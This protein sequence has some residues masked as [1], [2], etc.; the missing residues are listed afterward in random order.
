[1]Q[2]MAKPKEALKGKET[3]KTILFIVIFAS[4]TIYILWRLFFTLPL[5]HGIAS[6]V[7][8]I[9]LWIAESGTTVEAFWHFYNARYVKIPELPVIPD[10][11]YP[12]VDVLICTHNESREL[13]YKTLN[14]CK[15]MKYPDKSKV[16]IYLC[17]DANRPD[18]R[19]L[20][21]Q[22]NVGYF[23]F[24]GNKHAKAGN[25]NYALPH[26]SSPL[27]AIF[28]ADMIPTSEF[29]LETV[30][31][32][33]LRD[34][35]KKNGEWRMLL[36]YERR[37]GKELG[38]V[39][40]MQSFY[41][42][43]PLQRNLYMESEA[44]NEQDYFYRAV[45]VARTNS[46]SAAFAGS[47]TVFLRKALEDAGGFA[48]YSI[49][50]DLAT[51]IPILSSGYTSMAVDKELAHGLS[52]EDAFNFI[53]QRK[54]WSRGSAQVIPNMR[55]LRSKL[56]LKSKWSF[57]ISYFYWWTF[58]RRFIYLLT[59]ILYGLFGIAV[60]DVTLLQL[61]AVWL[62]Y[63]LIYN[64]GLRYMSGETINALWSS[65]IDTIQF[66][67]LM[68][69]VIAGT[70]K[71]PEKKFWVTP[72][73]RIKGRNSS[74]KLAVP[75]IVLTVLSIYSIT[76]CL[77]HIFAFRYSGAI[78]VLFW[79]VYNLFCLL[80][81][82]VYY[83]GRVN[84]RDYQRIPASVGATIH[85]GYQEFAG[86]T[87]YISEDSMAVL[88]KTPEY[89]PVDEDFAVTLQEGNYLATMKV[90]LNHVQKMRSRWRYSL[91][92]TEID[93]INKNEYLQIL[94][95][96]NHPYARKI[97][98]DFDTVIKCV[99]RGLTR[100]KSVQQ[101]KLP[102]ID[103]PLSLDTSEIGVVKSIALDYKNI[104]LS[105]N[106]EFP[107]ELTI[108]FSNLIQCVCTKVLDTRENRVNRKQRIALYEINNWKNLAK[109]P[110]FRKTIFDL[111]AVQSKD[112]QHTEKILDS[113]TISTKSDLALHNILY[114]PI[115]GEKEL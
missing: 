63:Y 96:R 81:S 53:K 87:I 9:I 111:M 22:M 90:R 12:D 115:K 85:T 56:P 25:L 94:Y 42:S 97:D 69:P 37:K 1:M 17:D 109:D 43:D 30:P 62:P 48:T 95:D 47:N 110:A 13:L 11:L 83:Y 74:L 20:T 33:F 75:H 73:E 60:A 93:A 91:S 18:I 24:D 16:H 89:L 79:L 76:V 66:P 2:Y 77:R 68:W 23:G 29:L 31:Y 6:L 105:G 106:K 44:P 107:N 3:S 86:Q 50:E 54:R 15:Y 102:Q 99:F 70:L 51:S 58:I 65:I 14:G 78:I 21:E 7:W 88:L 108:H 101:N 57:I 80:T 8:G 112:T 5:H 82:I 10:N 64:T 104:T 28:D 71:I 59:P 52:P 27:I 113:K 40:T 103:L 45:N 35:V 92:I 46:E 38:Y 72:K 19:R 114:K 36:P 39:Q 61:L 26:T 84:D 55:F 32:F 49:T 67:Y 34:M 4:S 100:K 41:N 98:V